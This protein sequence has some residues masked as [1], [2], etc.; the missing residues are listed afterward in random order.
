MATSNFTCP[1]C[2]AIVPA[3]TDAERAAA[4]RE[5]RR[6]AGSLRNTVW[7]CAACAVARGVGVQSA[8]EVT[9]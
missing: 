1:L 8:M 2:R 6:R 7:V 9:G 5:Q 3:V 4:A